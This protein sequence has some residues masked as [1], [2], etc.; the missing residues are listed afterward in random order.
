MFLVEA[1]P[2]LWH[3]FQ[4]ASFRKLDFRLEGGYVFGSSYVLSYCLNKKVN[5]FIIFIMTP[6]VSSSL[7]RAV[8]SFFTFKRCELVAHYHED[9][10]VLREA[11]WLSS[12][13]GTPTALPTRSSGARRFLRSRSFGHVRRPAV[14]IAFITSPHVP[15]SPLS[16]TVLSGSSKLQIFKHF[17]LVT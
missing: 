8:E 11:V 6:A 17:H 15:Y 3:N 9:L 16:F 2:L 14:L 4:E 13:D 7:S 12:V 1:F 5:R 10:H